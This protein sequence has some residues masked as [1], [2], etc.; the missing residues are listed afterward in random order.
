[1]FR[2][3]LINMN[4]VFMEWSPLDFFKVHTPASAGAA[5]VGIIQVAK[6]NGFSN[7]S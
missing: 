4:G 3:I 2:A 1:M 5:E 6:G 7:E